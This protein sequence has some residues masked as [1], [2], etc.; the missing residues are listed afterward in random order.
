MLGKTNDVMRMAQKREIRIIRVKFLWCC[1]TKA[2]QC[3]DSYDFTALTVVSVL[4]SGQTWQIYKLASWCSNI[5]IIFDLLITL[6]S[7]Q[8]C[9]NAA[10]IQKL[11]ATP[12]GASDTD[13]MKVGFLT[14]LWLV[15]VS[16][17]LFQSWLMTEMMEEK[18]SCYVQ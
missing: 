18:T 1:I 3:W 11:C 7:P 17:M 13:M 2:C 14:H 5:N 15:Q 6:K 9:V 4:S 12:D 16:N 10:D 8:K